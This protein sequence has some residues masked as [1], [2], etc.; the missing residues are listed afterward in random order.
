VVNL[1]SCFYNQL[2]QSVFTNFNVPQ[3]VQDEN[4]NGEVVVL[5]EVNAEGNL[6]LFTQMLFMKN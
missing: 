5:F 2:S 4:Y 1:K 6:W 3:V